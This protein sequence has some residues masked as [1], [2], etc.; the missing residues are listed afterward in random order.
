APALLNSTSCS[1]YTPV[2]IP[3]VCSLTCTSPALLNSTSCSCYTPVVTTPPNGTYSTL[4]VVPNINSAMK[5]NLRTILANGVALGN[6]PSVFAKVGDSITESGS[7]LTDIGCGG[8]DQFGSYASLIPVANYFMSTSLGSAPVWCGTGNSF[9]RASMTAVMGWTTSA[10][11]AATTAC[12]APYNTY[13]R[14]EYHTIRPSI[15]LIMYGT[16]DLQSPNNPT[17]FRANLNAIVDATIGDGVIPVLSTIPPRL[18]VVDGQAMG[19]RVAT[20]NQIIAD[21][22]ASKN[23][24]L[25]NFWA[26]TQGSS[27]S[28]QGMGSDGIHPSVLNSGANNCVDGADGAVLTSAG[29]RCGY[30]QR[31]LGALQILEKLKR[32]VLDDGAP[33]P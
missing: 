33:D 15:S 10:P 20:Y 9:T 31:N 19:P 3:P 23:I 6:R 22:A 14:C 2:V 5:A 29:L 26:Q 25:W 11:L 21:V 7:F 28:N 24:P 13:M 4:P 12:S 32:I 18:D 8:T 27:M 30:N 16:N 17:Q 1:C